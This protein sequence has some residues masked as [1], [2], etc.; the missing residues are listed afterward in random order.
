MK[1][2]KAIALAGAFGAAAWII[3]ISTAENDYEFMASQVDARI[4]ATSAVRNILNKKTGG[5]W[6]AEGYATEPTVS[7]VIR[8][9][10]L[11][12]KE[13]LEY[14]NGQS[15]YSVTTTFD[16]ATREDRLV[17][18]D[19]VPVLPANSLF[20]ERDRKN[21]EILM[22]FEASLP[23]SNVPKE[24]KY[25]SNK[26]LQDANLHLDVPVNAFMTANEHVY[27]TGPA[28]GS[29][30][31]DYVHKIREGKWIVK[32]GTLF[33]SGYILPSAE[34]LWSG[35][36]QRTPLDAD[37]GTKRQIPAV[38]GYAD[39]RTHMLVVGQTMNRYIE[40]SEPREKY[41]GIFSDWA[42]KLGL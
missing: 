34:L 24:F 40:L 8:D 25:H 32:S 19:G 15:H 26:T 4:N 7:R 31:V 13:W 16:K 6:E 36:G 22:K 33:D 17:M 1:L 38:T 2:V 21:I 5:G 28:D 41:P 35:N 39:M 12:H 20:E 23:L 29:A 9:G 11:T 42:R 18:Q 27:S 3:D 10:K 14:K 37:V 30:P